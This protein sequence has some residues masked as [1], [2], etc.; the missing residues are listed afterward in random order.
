[1]FSRIMSV[2]CLNCFSFL[3]CRIGFLARILSSLYSNVWEAGIGRWGGGQGKIALPTLRLLSS[4]AKEGGMHTLQTQ[5]RGKIPN[6]LGQT[7]ENIPL[8]QTFTPFPTNWFTPAINYWSSQRLDYLFTCFIFLNYHFE[9][10]I[11]KLSI[12][13]VVVLRE[14]VFVVCVFALNLW[15]ARLCQNRDFFFCE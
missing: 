8:I 10:F 3:G 13:Y 7:N 5:C 6:I 1:M 11:S 15:L 12:C 4:G 14:S 9:I 2:I